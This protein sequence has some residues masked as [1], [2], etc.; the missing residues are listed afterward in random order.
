MVTPVTRRSNLLYKS[1]LHFYTRSERARVR[2]RARASEQERDARAEAHGK[3]G[4][5]ANLAPHAISEVIEQLPD[6]R[7]A[8]KLRRPPRRALY[9]EEAVVH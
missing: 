4:E 2:V 9:V 5:D 8:A 7:A 6:L 1:A 3:R